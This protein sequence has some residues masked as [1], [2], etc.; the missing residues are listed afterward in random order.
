MSNAASPIAERLCSLAALRE[1][2]D[3]VGS[4]SLTEGL[5]F[6]E[7]ATP[8]SNAFYEADPAGTVQQRVR[9]AVLAHFAGRHATGAA[10]SPWG[11]RNVYAIAP[12]REW[13]PKDKRRALLALR[14]RAPFAEYALTEFAFET[15]DVEGPV[16]LAS[17]FLA[18]RYEPGTFARY[19]VPRPPVREFFVCTHGHVDICC[20][21][22]G[23]PL[24]A[25]LRALPGV[26]AWRTSH[27]GGHRF[28]PTVKEFPSGYTWGFV[29]EEAARAIVSRRPQPEVLARAVRGWIGVDGP[30]QALDREGLSRFGWDWMSFPRQGAILDGGYDT[31]SWRGR[32]TF[33]APN[34][35]GAIEGVVIRA[36]E[37]PN[38]GCGS[39]WG[40]N[41]YLSPEYRVASVQVQFSGVTG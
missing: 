14:P 24:Y 37:L 13:S 36:R 9:A 21:K 1:G 33:S 8:W 38:A 31:G 5:L 25:S 39:T 11:L 6:I 41:E 23:I 17:A 15:S 27:F 19:E 20:A 10:A 35:E 18:E 30:L 4:V 29:D 40:Q 3:P 28:A 34:G 2:Q 26:R 32:M 12:D 22:F 16:A 7:A